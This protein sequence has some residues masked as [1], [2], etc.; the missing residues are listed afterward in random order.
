VDSHTSKAIGGAALAPLSNIQKRDL[1]LLAKR[2]WNAWGAQR[3]AEG[4]EVMGF[5][6]WRH[7]EQRMA[8]ERRSLTL[9]TQEDFN[10][11][12]AHYL[13]LLGKGDVANALRIKA[14]GEPRQWALHRLQAEC[15]KAADVLPHAR[16]YVG[17]FLRKARGCTLDNASPKALWHGIYLIRRRA[18]QLRRRVA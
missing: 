2:A 15:D 16:E 6:D 14:E 8:V 1:I 17:G 4:Q 11:L 18:A 9:C 3:M 5:D 13:S 12:R 7:N 10:F